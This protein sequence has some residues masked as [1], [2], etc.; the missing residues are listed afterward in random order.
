MR[1]TLFAALLL[2]SLT[3]FS[4]KYH[5][6]I[7]TYTTGDSK[8]IYVYQF[9]AAT[10]AAKPVSTVMTENPSYLALAPG[11]KFLYAVNETNGSKPGG[12]STFAFDKKK[13]QLQFLGKQASG[14]DD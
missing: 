1:N 4:Q 2:L 7:G 14:G 11:G 3:G 10:G 13:G 6:F 8:G 5:L 9:D 12:V